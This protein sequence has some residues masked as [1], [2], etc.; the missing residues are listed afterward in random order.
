VCAVL[1]SAEGGAGGGARLL[2]GSGDG[3]VRAWDARTGAALGVLLGG[4]GGGDGGDGGLAAAGGLFAARPVLA[5]A[6]LPGGA[7]AGAGAFFVLRAPP[8]APAQAPLPPAARAAGGEAPPPPPPPPP[9]L[10]LLSAARGGAVLQQYALPSGAPPGD[11]LAAPAALAVSATGRY[12]YSGLGEG[13]RGIYGWEVATGASVAAG[14]VAAGASGGAHE[15]GVAGLLA[16]PQRPVL[17]SWGEEGVMK[18][19]V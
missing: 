17:V 4:A 5:L 15:R 6:A 13:S 18:S 14:A 10:L 7:H 3:S 2:T 12:V 1:L 16:H 8:V 19:W 11:A 9:S